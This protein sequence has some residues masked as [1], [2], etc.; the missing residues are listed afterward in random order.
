MKTADGFYLIEGAEY[1]VLRFD[2]HHA[3]R[4]ESIKWDKGRGEHTSRIYH[5]FQEAC[6]ARNRNNLSLSS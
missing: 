3:C 6:K 5:S 2:T 4:V 1:F